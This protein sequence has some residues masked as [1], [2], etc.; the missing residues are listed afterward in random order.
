MLLQ[1][2]GIDVVA[3][4]ELSND[5]GVIA[6]HRILDDEN[7]TVYIPSVRTTASDKDGNREIFANGVV[8]VVDEVVYT[9]LIPGQTYTVTGTLMNRDT[10]EALL[11][12]AGQPYTQSK[13]FRAAEEDGSVSLSFRQ[14]WQ[15]LLQISPFPLPVLFPQSHCGHPAYG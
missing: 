3:F 10:G 9:K 1:S 15:S 5:Y 6:T 14:P 8:T 2:G 13:T 4:E 12:S 7:Q 11:D